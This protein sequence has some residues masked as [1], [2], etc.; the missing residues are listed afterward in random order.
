VR[1]HLVS[2]LIPDPP[3]PFPPAEP[4]LPRRQWRGLGR[5]A[6]RLAR[7]ATGALLLLTLLWAGALAY[8]NSDSFRTQLLARL[9][10]ALQAHT[11]LVELGD[12][13]AVDW[14][15][16]VRLGPVSVRGSK[17]EAPFLEIPSLRV[18]PSY[19]QLLRG[20]VVPATITL[21]RPLLRLDR[22]AQSARAF[23]DSLEH[24][25]PAALGAKRPASSTTLPDSVALF[26]EGLQLHGGDENA[27]ELTGPLDGFLFLSRDRSQDLLAA[28]ARLTFPGGGR[29]ILTA[30]RQHGRYTLE[31]ALTEL[32]HAALAEPLWK[33]LP[34]RLE[35]GSA[36]AKLRV[37]VADMLTPAS[38]SLRVAFTDA[39]FSGKRLAPRPVGPLSTGFHGEVDW[40]PQQKTLR[41]HP[42]RAWLGSEDT[43]FVSV[44]SSLTFGRNRTLAFEA[45]AKLPF[46]AL[47]KALPP[48]LRPEDSA[49]TAHGPVSAALRIQGP[50]GEP[51]AWTVETELDLRRLRPG[52][53]RDLNV[54]FEHTAVDAQGRQRN[55]II[56]PESSAF[57]PLAS[58][59]EHVV[60]A[61]LTSEDAGFFGH[62]GFEFTEIH[63]SLIAAIRG[64]RFRG[65]S[66]L[67]QQ[68]A[69]NLF[70][71]RERTLSRKVKEALITLA[72]EV[73][74]SKERLLEIY[75]NL[76]EW[77][78]NL[79]GI[80][81]ASRHYFG[82]EAAAL[83]PKQ[84]AF[85][86]TL[87]PNPNRYYG[88]YLK[89]SLTPR[90]EERVSILVTKLRDGGYLDEPAYR[91]ALAEPLAFH[92]AEPTPVAPR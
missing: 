57:V 36:E 59:P 20:Q 60:R 5:R 78:P 40:N 19:R 62:D 6:R 51:E 16:R 88:Y 4:S 73:S 65:A 90:W 34:V 61:V 15:G 22:R 47:V 52:R 1:L 75:L 77:G 85:L 29:A 76:I 86:A 35:Q 74:V 58:L 31:V 41:L 70:L 55:L 21:D 53:A 23:W 44:E 72:L 43:L 26:V 18:R 45:V 39:W 11:G 81:E 8:L 69:K 54:P 27:L 83:T 3:D 92:R 56:G 84:A 49:P 24:P 14:L 2:I 87:I 13:L 9:R 33:A 68:L 63:D 48:Q 42:A 66:T 79:Y 82:V 89:G 91:A 7:I 67:T 28:R 30:Q 50:P 71:T 37:E 32:T 38:A 17:A 10:T 64:T 12:E 80:G 25:R 46:E